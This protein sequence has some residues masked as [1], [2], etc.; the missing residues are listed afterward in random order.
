MIEPLLI[1][2]WLLLEVYYECL[3]QGKANG[4]MKET[5]ITFLIIITCY[6]ILGNTL[7]NVEIPNEALRIRVIA[8]SNSTYDQEIKKEVKEYVEQNMYTLLKDTTEITHAREKIKNELPT[9]EKEIGILLENKNYPFSYEV[10]FGYNYFPEKEYKGIIYEEGIYESLVVSLGEAKGDNWWC[11]L[12]PPLCLLEAEESTEVEYRSFV[13]EMI[14]N[15][16]KEE[17]VTRTK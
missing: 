2:V 17:N 16:N 13:K 7:S 9:L 11:V 6:T 12:F 10:N 4:F 1:S 15:I 5:L 3:E 14:D 8:N